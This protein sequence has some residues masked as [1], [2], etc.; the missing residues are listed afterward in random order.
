L[1]DDCGHAVA[2]PLVTLSNLEAHRLL[3]F[4]NAISNGALFHLDDHGVG[5]RGYDWSGRYP[6]IAKAAVKLQARL[7]DLAHSA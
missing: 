3:S 5:S 7:T 1:H 2:L 4:L 6:S